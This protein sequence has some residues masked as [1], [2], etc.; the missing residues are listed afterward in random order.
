VWRTDT[1]ERV[2][3]HSAAIASLEAALRPK[4]RI[5]EHA[6]ALG[7]WIVRDSP[8]GLSC[9]AISIETL[10]DAFDDMKR[11]DLLEAVVELEG[12][13]M[14]DVLRTNGGV[15]EVYPLASLFSTFDGAAL[16]YDTVNDAVHLAQL[17]LAH[18]E[19]ARQTRNLDEEAKLP[20]RRFN[21]AVAMLLPM[22]VPGLVSRQKQADYPAFGFVVE[23]TARCR[24]RQFLADQGM[25]VA[26]NAKA[27]R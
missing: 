18:P 13:G 1:S 25:P 21:P 8:A 16:G 22:M 27:T 7:A 5:T 2:N 26:Q 23:E 4:L 10:D 12:L 20:R 3:D 6:V 11:E 24:L 14:L 15:R 17:L 19:L 9:P